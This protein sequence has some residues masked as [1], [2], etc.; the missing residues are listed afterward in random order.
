LSNEASETDK[1]TLDNSFYIDVGPRL[2]IGALA[3]LETTCF[4]A[5]TATLTPNTR[6][7]RN[8]TF[9]FRW[10]SPYCFA[11]E[12]TTRYN[13]LNDTPYLPATTFTYAAADWTL[14]YDMSQAVAGNG[15]DLANTT[16][17]I[18]G[19]FGDVG[20]VSYIYK[21]G[22]EAKFRGWFDT[23][24]SYR[25][26]ENQALNLD[27]TFTNF[28][29]TRYYAG[30]GLG[31]EKLQSKGTDARFDTPL[32]TGITPETFTAT[33]LSEKD[34]R[35]VVNPTKGAE[36][37]NLKNIRG[38]TFFYDGE[39]D[40]SF[41]SI[42]GFKQDILALN[43]DATATKYL[44][45]DISG[46]GPIVLN[47]RINSLHIQLTNLPIQS[48][49]GVVSSQNTTIAV[50]GTQNATSYDDPINGN[51]IYHH[52][53]NEI[54]WIDLNNIGPLNFNKI[55]VRITYD[56]NTSASSLENRSDVVVM[57]RQK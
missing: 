52:Y 44:N 21:D 11:V 38:E 47:E 18:P 50:V 45:Y 2:D 23:R 28:F 7:A 22:D 15:A 33:G 42:I 41:G 5:S 4:N 20:M 9:R 48:Q 51:H 26:L 39:P 49:N 12:Y 36:T 6:V 27:K 55:D 32:L 3:K 46:A 54:Q 19:W 10:T 25:N 24:K 57:F 40:S 1:Y 29:D 56:D 13:S 43:P 30:F 17:Y 34:I 8:L 31:F 14:M 35:L 37:D 53:A 16:M